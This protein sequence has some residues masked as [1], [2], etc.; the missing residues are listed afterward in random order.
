M[1]QR[2]WKVRLAAIVAGG[3]LLINSGVWANPINLSLDDSVALALKNNPSLQIAVAGKDKSLW[4]V[5]Q[6]RAGRG[7]NLGFT[8]VD[9]R[10]DS[11]W[12][13]GS[14]QYTYNNYFTNKATLTLPLYTGG[15]LEGLIDESKE[16][17]K[18]SGL[19]VDA[20]KQQLKLSVTT[21]YYNVLQTKNLLAVSTQSV[22]DFTAHLKNVQAQYDVGTVAKS[23]VLQTKVQLANAQDGLIKAQ[24]NYNL[25]V[26]T[27]ANTIGLPLDS[28]IVLNGDLNYQAFQLTLDDSVKYALTHRPEIDQAKASIAAADDAIKV[29]RSGNLP[30]LSFAGTNGWYD[31]E[32]AGTKNSNWMV[33]L[34]LS[35]NVLD[36]GLTKSEVKQA[37]FSKISSQQQARQTSDNIALEVRQAYLSMK[38]A[39]ERIGTSKVAVDQ[40]NEDYKI[41]EVR[42]TAGVGTNLDVIDAQLSLAQAETNYIQAL[43][44]YDTSKA[45]LDKAMGTLVK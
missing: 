1:I 19:N 36:S 16:N 5:E 21:Q 28:E 31:K 44:D 11:P 38:E 35:L 10:Y 34:N 39:E 17:Y 2:V 9:E 27:L 22:A 26:A 13:S 6:A 4:T 7:F 12:Y 3:V 30:T 37:E 15:K 18:I 25:A 40:A 8:H 14:S 42:Y 29:A 43:F 33:S 32:F 45:Q 41:A 23:D 20:T 24:N